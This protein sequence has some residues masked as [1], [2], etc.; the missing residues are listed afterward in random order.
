MKRREGKE[1]K[2]AAALRD[3]VDRAQQ[4]GDRAEHNSGERDL[5]VVCTAGS[6]YVKDDSHAEATV[7]PDEHCSRCI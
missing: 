4:T 6:K 2:S 7:V 1:W 3:D 5:A